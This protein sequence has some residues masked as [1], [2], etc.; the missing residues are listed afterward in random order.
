MNRIGYRFLAAK[1][2][3]EPVQPFRVASQLG[4]RRK[5]EAASGYTVQTFTA[6]SAPAD[7]VAAHLAF[8]LKH[9]GVHLELLARLFSKIGPQ[10]MEEWIR[11]APT[12]IYA[13]QACFFYEWLLGEPLDHPGVAQGNYVPALDPERYLTATHT[14]NNTRWRIRDNLPG[15]PEYCPT[16]WRTDA[17]KR[18]EA[19]DCTAQLDALGVEFGEELLARSAVWLTIKESMQ[20]FAIERESDKT[21]RVRRFATVM[22]QR[23]GTY[24]AP[25]DTVALEELQTEILGPSLAK[26]GLRRSPVFVGEASPYGPTVVHYMAPHWDDIAG[27]LDGLAAFGVKTAGNPAARLARAAVMSFGFVYIHP[28][29][30]GNGRVSRFLVNDTLRRDEAVPAPF[31]LPVSATITSSSAQR[32]AYDKILEVFS[33]PLMARYADAYRFGAERIAEDGRRY[34]IEFLAYADA[35]PAWRYPDL[36]DHV[37]YLG[38]VIA[39]TI[40]QHMR[41]EAAHLHQWRELRAA[42][43]NILDGP[44]QDIDRII[45]SVKDNGGAMSNKLRGEFPLLA[46]KDIAAAIVRVI[47][48]GAGI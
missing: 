7:N 38:G 16:V 14:S 39:E 8:A 19:Y 23:T 11:A 10:P 5:T 24:D 37:V 44:D 36:T 9:E 47:S 22:E 32:R 34:D 42:I 35:R 31:I 48:G 21:D 29:A 25:L 20:S 15:T 17:V 46:D 2:D 26:V 27:M 3:A 18:G 13:R 1:F 30:D 41:A 6:S 45:R 40:E 43:K 28:L 4:P 12:S 33:K